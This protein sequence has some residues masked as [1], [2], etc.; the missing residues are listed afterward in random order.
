MDASDHAE[1]HHGVAPQCF[2]DTFRCQRFQFTV[3]AGFQQWACGIVVINAG[4]GAVVR[5]HEAETVA[6]FN[7]VEGRD[8]KVFGGG[9][10]CAENRFVQ[11]ITMPFAKGVVHLNHDGTQRV[12]STVAIPEADGFEGVAKDAGVAVQPDFARCVGYAF[13][14]KHSSSQADEVTRPSLWIFG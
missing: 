7:V 13:V 5:C 9:L 6:A 2:A 4:E 12:V 1:C 3:D 8:V 14:V 11:Q 10:L